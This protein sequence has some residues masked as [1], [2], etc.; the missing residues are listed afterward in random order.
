MMLYKTRYIFR[1]DISYLL[2]HS[3]IHFRKYGLLKFNNIINIRSYSINKKDDNFP[4]NYLSLKK[5][6]ESFC[7]T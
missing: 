6:N 5:S 1:G 4:Y 2:Y 3:P 7:D